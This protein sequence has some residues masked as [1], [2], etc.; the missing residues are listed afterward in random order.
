MSYLHRLLEDVK[1]HNFSSY[2]ERAARL[3]VSK[4]WVEI[5][6]RYLEERKQIKRTKAV[7]MQGP[8]R[9]SLTPKGIVALEAMDHLGML[10]RR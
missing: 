8:D 7:D 10:L 1:Q 3:K 9:L 4:T 2:Y 6:V 5:V